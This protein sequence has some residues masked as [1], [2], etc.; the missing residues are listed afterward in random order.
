MNCRNLLVIIYL[1]IIYI[2]VYL[3]AFCLS[4]AWPILVSSSRIVSLSNAKQGNSEVYEDV[5]RLTTALQSH[6]FLNIYNILLWILPSYSNP[7][8]KWRIHWIQNIILVTRIIPTHFYQLN[9]RSW[10]SDC[11]ARESHTTFFFCFFILFYFFFHVIGKIQECNLTCVSNSFV[12]PNRKLK[13]NG[14][15]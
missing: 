11:I 6:Y 7:N 5:W 14:K 10:S 12:Y 9:N 13:L 8:D 15:K 2:F 4:T 3:V 1:V